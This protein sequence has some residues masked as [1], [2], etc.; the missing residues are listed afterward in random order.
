DAFD[1]GHVLFLIDG[2]L[3]AREDKLAKLEL[4]L[5][6]G[7]PEH[8]Q[9]VSLRMVQQ[10]EHVPLDVHALVLGRTAILV[11][12]DRPFGDF[13]AQVVGGAH[14]GDIGDYIARLQINGLFGFGVLV[15]RWLA[16]L[17]RFGRALG[18]TR[19]VIFELQGQRAGGAGA[20]LAAVRRR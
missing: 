11:D 9:N 16:W 17:S 2:Y 10:I 4:G 1:L 3:G 14:A 8:V 18:R 6:L 19:R 15:R 20:G 5:L 7:V 13:L 12:M